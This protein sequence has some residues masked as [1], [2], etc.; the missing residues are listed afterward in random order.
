MLVTRAVLD[1]KVV[2]Q[3][4][5]SPARDLSLIACA[6]PT[7]IIFFFREKM[8]LCTLARALLFILHKYAGGE[9]Q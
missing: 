6:L 7:Y 4:P 9:L 3:I 5:K 1:L 8:A 2:R